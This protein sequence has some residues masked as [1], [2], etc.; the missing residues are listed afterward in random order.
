MKEVAVVGM[1]CRMPGGFD[2]IGL[3]WEGLCKGVNTVSE[4]PLH[5]WSADWHYSSDATSPGKAYVRRANFLRQDIRDM[6]AAFFDIPP[7]V[8]ENLDPQQRVMLEVVWEAFENAGIPLPSL[9]GENVGVYVGGFMLDHMVNM[10]NPDNAP[11]INQNT[12]AGM[13]M[14]M[15]SNRIS[16]AFDLRGPSL[17]IDTACSSSLTAFNYGVQDVQLG[18]CEVA[19]VGGVNIMTRPEYPVGMSKGQFLSRD[20]E[21]KSFD[22]RGDGY[23][24]AEGAGVVVLKDLSQAIAD[25]D[26]IL[27]KVLATGVNS[28]GRTPG[29]S[30][31][32]PEAQEALASK[33]CV[34][35]NIDPKSVH[36]VECHG[37]GT[38]VGDPIEAG[39]IGQVFGKGRSGDDR[40]VIGSIKSNIGHSEA[41]AGVAGVI[42]AVLTLNNRLVTPLGNLQTP[43]SSI[44]FEELGVR[45]GD[46]LIPLGQNGETLR[47]A[48]NSFGYGGTNAFA[49]IENG[50][51]KKPEA[52]GSGN[53]ANLPL[54]LPISARSN[55]A[56]KELAVQIINVLESSETE[57][58]DV[59]YTAACKRAHLTHRAVAMG[60]SATDLIESLTKLS[61]GDV[62]ETAVKNDVPF[63][64]NEEPV[65]VFTGMGPQWWGMGQE[66]YRDH[67]EFRDAL[68]H[69]D[70][71]FTRISGFSILAEMLKSEAE[72]EITKTEF[73]QPAN[74]MI[75]YGLTKIMETAGVT[76][77]AIV[78][79]SVGEVGSAFAAGALTLEDALTVSYH[80]SRT[81]AKTAGMG[82]MLAV[83]LGRTNLEP[84]LARFDGK[85]DIAAVNGPSSMTVSGDTISIHSLS[86]ELTSAEVFNRVL[87]VEVPYHSYLM[88]SITDEL[89]ESL[90]GITPQVP[91]RMLFSTVT[92]QQVDTISYDGTYWAENVRQPVLFMDAIKNLMDKGYST[93]VEMGPQPVLSSALRD[94]G[95]TFG[96]DIR[97]VETLRRGTEKKPAL[98]ELKA[99][100][101]AVAGTYA[102]GAT[103]YWDRIAPNGSMVRLPNYP[104]QRERHWL[105]TKQGESE[106][107]R[108]SRNPLLGYSRTSA[109][110]IWR[111]VITH[112]SVAY[113]G[114]HVVS[115]TPVMPAA[116]Y[117]EMM[118]QLGHELFD[119]VAGIDVRNLAIAGPML[120][121]RSRSAE[122]FTHF[123]PTSSEALIS[124]APSGSINE[125]TLHVSAEIGR[126]DSNLV[127]V[128][129]IAALRSRF[130][131]GSCVTSLYNRLSGLGLQYGPAFQAIN[132]VYLNPARGDALAF[133]ELN[134]ELASKEGY[135]LHPSLLDG[136]FQMLMGVLRDDSTMYLPTGF[137][138]IRVLCKQTPT[139]VWCYGRMVSQTA[140]NIITDLTLFDEAGRTVAEV[141]GMQATASSNKNK[142]Q[143]LDKFGDPVTLEEME[144]E[145]HPGEQLDEPSRMG[146]WLVFADKGQES[147]EELV[148]ELENMGAMAPVLVTLGEQFEFEEDEAV[149]RAG[150]NDDCA[151]LFSEVGDVH[152]IA[153]MH[154]LASGVT[155]DPTGEIAIE[156]MLSVSKALHGLPVDERPRVYYITQS[157]FVA[158]TSET[159]VNPAQTAIGGFMRVAHNEIEGTKATLVDMPAQVDTS[160]IEAVVAELLADDD[161][162]EVALR[163]GRR[164][165][166][167]IALSDAPNRALVVDTRI[168]DNTQ[169]RVRPSSDQDADGM[170]SFAELELPAC[171]AGE[172]RVRIADM[173]LPSSLLADPNRDTLDQS[174]VA[175]VGEVEAVGAE[176]MDVSCGQRIFGYAPAEFASHIQ[177]PRQ[178][179]YI[180]HL[181]DSIDSGDALA[182]LETFVIAKYA[183]GSANLDAGDSALVMI[184]DP[185]AAAIAAELESMDVNVVQVD[186]AASQLHEAV[187]NA[188]ASNDGHHFD[189]VVAPLSTWVKSVGIECVASAGT[190]VDCDFTAQALRIPASVSGIVR[191]DLSVATGRPKRLKGALESASVMLAQGGRVENQG[192]SIGLRDIV[193]QTLDI[194]PI[195]LRVDI[196]FNLEG[197]EVPIQVA[198]PLEFNPGATYLVTGGLGGF[199]MQTA[200]WLVSHGVQSLVLAS[201]SGANSDEKQAFVEQ[202]TASGIRV[203]TPQYD[204]SNPDA[205][206]EMVAWIESELPP[207]KGIF[208]SAAVIEDFDIKDLEPE[209]Y[210]RVMRSKATSGWALHEA[211]KHINL[212]HFVCYSS[213]AS[214]VGNRRQSAYSAANCYL[215]G[216]VRHR[217]HLGM[218][219]LTVMWGAIG[220]VGVVADSAET[221]QF[222]KYIGI[223]GLSSAEAL[224]RMEAYITR[225]ITEISCTLMSS[226][227]DWARYETIG[228]ESPRFKS[229]LISAGGGNND[230]VRD[231]LI[232]ELMTLDIGERNAVLTGLISAVIA[233]ELRQDPESLSI[234]RP[235]N[236]LGVDSLM[237]TEI[238][239]LM[240]QNLGISVSVMDLLGGATIRAISDQTLADFELDTINFSV[241]EQNTQ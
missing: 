89:I 39:S 30:M 95:R 126:I 98:P 159:D 9:S 151:R 60:D 223:R 124:S 199:G 41:L 65:F 64:G 129:D 231:Q 63:G 125:S 92:G 115:G 167:T 210:R 172:I 19:V 43:N 34:D 180:A 189:A 227:A 66:L 192:L 2:D 196:E 5:R 15:L 170:V 11:L 193:V 108:D 37:T 90:S 186:A 71:I 239:V 130:D 81:Q 84:F 171:A 117:I 235:I 168:D 147:A 137:K 177:A 78:G 218:S 128:K 85:I 188:V 29:I 99:F 12:A 28:D 51:E 20:G 204:L 222:L 109:A 214:I 59:L 18:R 3:L 97:L 140:K 17:S 93:F 206:K 70:A 224:D 4:V 118:L 68:D 237:A 208:H 217:R 209:V 154:G 40:V 62:D 161:Y 229:M 14:T 26:T 42:K 143:R 123:D 238:Q 56:L 136:C 55:N 160:I 111:N 87:N 202:L 134:K 213:I 32:S 127:E 190:L 121:N 133:L 205:V 120:L 116:G 174:F 228:A 52:G 27:A 182:V 54:M 83:G 45:L 220:D 155:I 25:G 50:P 1:S 241:A 178:N 102:A 73:A 158:D 47:A 24:R 49:V 225:D 77:G 187:E 142:S 233:N 38:A 53:I 74:F 219:G 216:L 31:P 150:S 195:D 58:N 148:S 146:R 113:L 67:D 236:D 162:D 8:A 110:N 44:P 200:S 122:V 173:S 80:R 82:S 234:D 112:D 105:E 153:F 215:S 163:G 184:N 79:H 35:N 183:A 76:P 36:Y 181:D 194:P 61:S 16:H 69:A 185:V 88:N 144:Y 72:S 101:C 175:I 191:C 75:Q 179:F 23:G 21:S 197:S 13:M 96:K 198:Q 203:E 91:S 230:E 221:E 176:S 149:I 232:A 145:W 152:G 86:E 240:G 207:L 106:R 33:T 100:H 48:V 166:S 94:C 10:M 141:R 157:A 114:D 57:I 6:D 135:F 156:T 169:Y 201:R 46:D 211:S 119:D 138:S 107:L 165:V 132:S 212:D 139:R 226:W 22:E 104:W 164:M 7:S 103:V 131:E